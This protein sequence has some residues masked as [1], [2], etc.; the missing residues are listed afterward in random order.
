MR[1]RSDNAAYNRDYKIE[2]AIS[3]L[4]EST[5][6]PNLLIPSAERR[7]PDFFGKAFRAF[8]PAGQQLSIFALLFYSYVLHCNGSCARL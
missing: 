5:K 2:T 7:F 3:N 8:A 4:M 1:H 6:S